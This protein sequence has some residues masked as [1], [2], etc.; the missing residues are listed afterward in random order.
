MFSRYVEF[1]NEKACE[2][3]DVVDLEFVHCQLLSPND[4][5]EASALMKN[6]KI[7]VRRVRTGEREAENERNRMQRDADR[8]YFKQLR[9]LMP[10]LGGGKLSDVV[11]D[12]RGKFADGRGRNQQV[13][14]TTVNVHSAFL[15]K[16]CRWLGDA[17]ERARV[18]ASRRSLVCGSNTPENGL[19]LNGC[20]KVLCD[21]SDGKT[22]RDEDD[23]GIEVLSFP[24]SRTGEGG[25][26]TEIENDDEDEQLCSAGD[27]EE[28]E[29]FRPGSPVLP[30]RQQGGFCREVL[31]ITLSDHSPEAVKL[32]LEYCY[33]NRVLPLGQEAFSQACKTKPHKHYGPVPPYITSSSGSRRWPSNGLPMVSFSVALAGISLA[34]DASMH[35]LSLMCEVAA[36]QLLTSSDIVEAL[37]MCTRQRRVTGNGLPKLRK[38]AMDFVLRSGSRGVVELSRT[39]SFRRALDE[40][41]CLLIPALLVGT[42]EAVGNSEKL[43]KEHQQCLKRDRSSLNESCYDELDRI[44]SYE[45][46]R[47]RRKRR[48]ER[49]NSESADLLEQDSD[50]IF[51]SARWDNTS[52]STKRSLKRRSTHMALAFSTSARERDTH[53]FGHN[54]T[55]SFAGRRSSTRRRTAERS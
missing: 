1:C 43:R 46:E 22:G 33:T 54:R 18:E 29:A 15:G 7:Y 37:S 8:D 40:S 34:E 51:D 44:D 6:D 27:V 14:S 23:D 41:A 3:V 12:C 30:T 35:R 20:E 48:Q 4:T 42:M 25:G 45:R 17:I 32:L 19:D 52:D 28:S 53:G 50:G 5:A 24:P 16:R 13:L 47:E 49:R 31:W 38:A 26:A 39:P 21:E 11:L 10:D 9:N 36:T 55:F 2:R